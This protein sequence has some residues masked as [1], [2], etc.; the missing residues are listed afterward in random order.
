MK[1]GNFIKRNSE[2]EGK[3]AKAL[4]GTRKSWF[5]NIVSHLKKSEVTDEFWDEMEELL[6]N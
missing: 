4:E 6:K 3:V 1:L 5:G 2:D